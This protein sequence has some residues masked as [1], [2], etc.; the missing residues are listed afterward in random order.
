MA[1]WDKME[2]KIAG[3][4]ERNSDGRWLRG[5]NTAK[6]LGSHSQP[7][8]NLMK[9][10]LKDDPMIDKIKDPELGGVRLDGG[11]SQ[12]SLRS[13]KYIRVMEEF[14]DL[15]KV[16]HVTDFGG[17]YGN[18]C[19]V[20]HRT[21]NYNG[22]YLHIDLPTM[23]EMQQEFLAPLGINADYANWQDETFIKPK[24]KSMF[25]ATFS[26]TECS[27]EVR[28]KM[29]PYIQKHDYIF[30]IHNKEFDGIDN[31]NWTRNT[32]IAAL[33]E[34]HHCKYWFDEPS[35]KDW[36]MAKKV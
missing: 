24:A 16:K 2:T 31:R 15:K 26:L 27:M 32:L 33:N 25:H 4:K 3:E 17:G 6:A 20:W 10:E 11:I 7:Y 12:N 29:L 30:L 5:Y 23:H 13:L 36:L 34:T 35:A 18:F 28:D 14:M 9:Q 8:V 19:R 21:M 1:F 22:R